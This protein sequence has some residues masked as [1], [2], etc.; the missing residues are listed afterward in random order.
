MGSQVVNIPNRHV[1]DKK[2]LAQIIGK[3]VLEYSTS[4]GAKAG[5]NFMGTLL[6]LNVKTTTDE[7]HH[8]VIKS[9]LPMTGPITKD[10][11]SDSKLIA[12]S[13]AYTKE[14][15]YYKHIRPLFQELFH[16]NAE[17]LSF[18]EGPKFYPSLHD[19]SSQGL[20]D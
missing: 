9:V 2:F 20:H 19:A 18:F 15:V 12:D 8:L 4:A 13:D 14:I 10:A 3:P 6:S 5:D 17:R 11:W 7:V 1:L 16:N